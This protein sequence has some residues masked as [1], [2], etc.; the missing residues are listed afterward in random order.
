MILSY[1]T[2]ISYTT[3]INPRHKRTLHVESGMTYG[4][5]P[6][7]YD[8]RIAEWIQME[9]GGF[10]LASSMEE[11]RMPRNICGMVKDKSTLARMGIAVQNTVIEPGWN[12]FLTLEISKHSEGI[13]TLLAGQPIAQIIFQFLDEPT[14]RPY[15]GKYQNQPNYP[16]LPIQQIE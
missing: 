13:V 5:G 10:S 14:E 8:I 6:C 1:Q 3:M 12:G 7:G 4:A 9:K 15:K 16:V 11:F 2:L